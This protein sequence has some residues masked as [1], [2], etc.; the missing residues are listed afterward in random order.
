MQCIVIGNNRVECNE[1]RR[2]DY[3][4][5]FFARRRQ[6]YK[7]DPGGLIRMRIIGKDGRERES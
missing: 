3:D 4:K 1:I 7:M 5:R 6:L 2:K